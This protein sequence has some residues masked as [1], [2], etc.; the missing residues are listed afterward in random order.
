M[1]R[2]INCPVGPSITNELIGGVK[3]G[4]NLLKGKLNRRGSHLQS[5]LI[6]FTY[7]LKFELCTLSRDQSAN[8]YETTGNKHRK[9][10]EKHRK[11]IIKS[12]LGLTTFAKFM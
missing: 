11:R 5:G 1:Q 6:K 8:W 9:W 4:L 7:I 10:R 3:G 12:L 2:I